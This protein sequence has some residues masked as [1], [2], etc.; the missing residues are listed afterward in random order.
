MAG[1]T[2]ARAYY[3]SVTVD[4]ERCDGRM[5]CLR[6]CPTGAIRVR[7][8]KAAIIEERC[9]DCGECI[10]ACPSGAFVPLAYPLLDATRFRVKV[11]VPST[12]LYSQFQPEVLPGQVLAALRAIGF[13]D[14]RDPAAAC[15]EV[16]MAIQEYIAGHRGPWPLITST[17]PAVVR[18]IQ[19]K[20]P[21]LTGQVLP[22]E[23]PREIA[24]RRVK[25]EKAAELGLAPEE[26]AA[27]Y[28]TPCPAKTVSI[29]QPAEKERSALDGVV[30]IR[31]IYN[32][33]LS[34]MSGSGNGPAA[35]GG[36]VETSCV[37]VSW[38]R[39]G[40]IAGALPRRQQHL[41]V[42]G[43]KNV[44][45]ILDDVENGMLR[46]IQLLECHSCLG[47]C[48]GGSLTVENV[49][50]ARRKVID[51]AQ[52]YPRKRMTPE[53][54]RSVLR[55][56]R[57]GFYFLER[58]LLPRPLLP[59]D[60]DVAVA[61]QKM[62]RKGEICKELP[63]IDCG[64]C[65]SPSCEDFAEDLV[66]EEVRLEDCVFKK[67]ELLGGSPPGPGAAGPAAGDRRQGG[68]PPAVQGD[69]EER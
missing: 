6:A 7:R 9:I 55:L 44:M 5:A 53:R 23:V 52:R 3:H 25:A 35:G 34:A 67:L 36:G 38:A 62:R 57:E 12:V 64:A 50:V 29:R 63:G 41:T 1:R 46:G 14:A 26:I 21:D 45:R 15:E 56:Y 19:V 22:I 8:G 18:L 60:P 16:G 31:D 69:A 37:G 28:V 65:G 68:G 54:R 27:I 42:S 48:I 2:G 59:L 32:Q 10:G 49:Y 66:K 24:A 40:G 20:Y 39:M 58:Q 47:G 43:L 30:A 61:I 33:L 17:C 13:D 51:L 4:R 11:A